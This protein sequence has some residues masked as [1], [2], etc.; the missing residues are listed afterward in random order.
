M[1]TKEYVPVITI[2]IDGANWKVLEILIKNDLC[3][4]ISE[5]V[6]EGTCAS[7]MVDD[8]FLSPVIWTSVITGKKGLKHGIRGLLQDSLELK[9]KTI[10][11]ILNKYD[12][13]SGLCH[14]PVTS[15]PKRMA[16]HF[17]IPLYKNT[18]ETYPPEY[19]F[20]NKMLVGNL[21]RNNSFAH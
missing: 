20:I 8:V 2:G 5:L 13:S 9:C 10:C 7:T 11:D 15:P 17:N 14:W 19:S 18:I 16:N 1:S 21:N 6:N 4:N 12:I 3:P